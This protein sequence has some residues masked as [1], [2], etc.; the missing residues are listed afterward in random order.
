MEVW[1]HSSS[2]EVWIA[3][4]RPTEDL[5]QDFPEWILVQLCLSFRPSW[6]WRC[7]LAA[8]CFCFYACHLLPCHQGIMYSYYTGTISTNRLSFFTKKNCEVPIHVTWWDFTVALI[9]NI[10]HSQSVLCMRSHHSMPINSSRRTSADIVGYH[11]ELQRFY[12][13]YD[14]WF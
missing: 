8:S 10:Q 3:P 14:S 5:W 9:L 11:Y 6:S 2:Y 13:T 4:E 1:G 7:H 12:C